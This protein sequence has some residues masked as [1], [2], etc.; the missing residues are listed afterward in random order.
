MT[1][2]LIFFGVSAKTG[3]YTIFKSDGTAA[4]PI[5]DTDLGAEGGIGFELEAPGPVL[6]DYG[7]TILAQGFSSEGDTVLRI[8]TKPVPPATTGAY[9][10]FDFEPTNPAPS[11]GFVEYKGLVYFNG[12]VF[13]TGS[14]LYS[15]NGTVAGTSPITASNLNPSSLAVAYNKLFFSGNSAS[16]P[17]LYSY[18]GSIATPPAPV[19]VDVLNPSSLA[20]AFVNTVYWLPNPALQFGPH[21]PLFMSGQD[22]TGT[23]LFQYDGSSL[24]KIAPSRASSSGL[25]PYNLVNLGWVE[26]RKFGPFYLETFHR[27]LCFS[28]TSAGG[29]QEVWISLGT[30]ETTTMIPMPFVSNQYYP[31]NLT[32]FNGMLYFTAYDTPPPDPPNGRGLFVYD[33]V[34]NETRQIIE[35]SAYNLDPGNFQSDWSDLSQYTMAVFNNKLYFNATETNG[36]P[37][38]WYIDGAPPSGQATPTLVSS[39][40]RLQPF[41]L[42]TANL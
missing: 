35:S 38:L 42:T 40:E 2:A 32:P 37:S 7:K 4:A 9:T 11:F 21:P 30:T 36:T 34:K 22:S 27:V 26:M 33:P 41:S 23:W 18:D 15:T 28:G 20:V 1:E 3:N 13:G 29:A 6:L 14:D 8:Y 16:G 10:L 31:Y 24:T 17:I 12:T 25:A 5:S 39:G 19:G